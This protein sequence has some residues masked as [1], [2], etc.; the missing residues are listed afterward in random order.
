MPMRFNHMELTF[1]RGELNEETRADIDR[2]Y[3]DVL[4][5]RCQPNELFG[6]LGHLLLPDEGQFILLMEVDEP[7]HSPSYDHLGLLLDTREEVDDLLDACR[8]FQEKDDR[9]RLK[10]FDDIAAPRVTQHAFYV[11]YLLPIWFDVCSLEYPPG[12]EP[13][14]HWEFVETQAAP[15]A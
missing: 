7:I 3:G 5:W 15:G 9:L 14:R 11:R 2:F 8:R 10:L 12:A 1:G 4:N 13:A 6:Q